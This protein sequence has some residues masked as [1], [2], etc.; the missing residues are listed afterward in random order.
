MPLFTETIITAALVSFFMAFLIVIDKKDKRDDIIFFLRAWP[1]GILLVL[2]VTVANSVT[3]NR[4]TYDYILEFLSLKN[5][6]IW[7]FR[8]LAGLGYIF[9]IVSSVAFLAFSLK[10]IIRKRKHNTT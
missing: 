10:G 1:A 3:A 5:V 6:G 4:W 8:I 2:G 7:T 9:I